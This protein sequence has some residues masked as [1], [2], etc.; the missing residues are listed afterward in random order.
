[1]QYERHETFREALRDLIGAR[2][3]VKAAAPAS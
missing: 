1:V 2:K 3:A